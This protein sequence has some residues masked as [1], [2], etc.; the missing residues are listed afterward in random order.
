MVLL[1]GAPAANADTI[2][3]ASSGGS[4][5]AFSLT[6]EL[7]RTLGYATVGSTTFDRYDVVLDSFTGVA[8][9]SAIVDVQGT[10]S[11]TGSAGFELAS[12]AAV[13]S[14]DSHMSSSSTWGS[15]TS[16]VTNVFPSGYGQ[17]AAPLSLVNLDDTVPYASFWAR[18]GDGELFSSFTGYWYT[19][20]VDKP[21]Y[22][23][24]GDGSNSV[25]VSLYLP[26]GWAPSATSVLS[27]TGTLGFSYGTGN[28]QNSELYTVAPEPATSVLLI[29]GLLALPA[30][31]KLGRRLR[32]A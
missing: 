22:P 7:D 30:C 5:G 28:T 8:V 13:S 25:L 32:T 23:G 26:A 29:A 19:A 18:T 15:Y 10:W 12:D 11:I 14:Y 4:S 3:M 9:G 2:H 21:L 20:I 31:S 17:S 16:N 24:D 6:A 1:T 27:Y